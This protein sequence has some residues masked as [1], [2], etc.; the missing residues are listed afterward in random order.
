VLVEK[1]REVCASRLHPHHVATGLR[2]C[3][4]S[5]AEQRAKISRKSPDVGSA[6]ETRGE[7]IFFQFS[8]SLIEDWVKRNHAYDREFEVGHQALA[9]D[10]EPRPEQGR[11]RGIRFVLAAHLRPRFD[12]AVGHRMWVHE[13]LDHGA[14]LLPQ[15]G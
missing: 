3:R 5:A 13:R 10:Q 8:E 2:Q 14:D 15:S 1:L 6:S 9:G 12:P 11:I 7:G 4:R